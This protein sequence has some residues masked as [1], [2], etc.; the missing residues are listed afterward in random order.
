MQ[1]A[2]N[3]GIGAIVFGTLAC[4]NPVD[5]N[6]NVKVP[7]PLIQE[8]DGDGLPDIIFGVNVHIWDTDGHGKRWGYDDMYDVYYRK[9]IGQG[10]FA[11]PKFLLRTDKGYEPGVQILYFREEYSGKDL[12]DKPDGKVSGYNL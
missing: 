9:N 4:N 1:L 5:Q 7:P 8:I 6:V 3:L 10:N 11:Q 12:W 2:R